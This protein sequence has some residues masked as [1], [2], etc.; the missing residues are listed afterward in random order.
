MVLVGNESLRERILSGEI[1][2]QACKKQPE[3]LEEA[4][5]LMIRVLLFVLARKGKPWWEVVARGSQ[6]ASSYRTLPCVQ[7][8]SY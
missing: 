3:N 8:S 7:G 6:V 1:G 2:A 5:A 4:L